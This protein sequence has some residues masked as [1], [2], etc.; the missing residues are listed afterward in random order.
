MSRQHNVPTRREFL[1]QV[2]VVVGVPVAALGAGIGLLRWYNERR[3]V[4]RDGPDR[5]EERYPA[6]ERAE[7]SS[8]LTDRDLEI[9]RRYEDRR[10]EF[11][12]RLYKEEGG[13]PHCKG[14]IYD[15]KLNKLREY[16]KEM[17]KAAEDPVSL[18]TEEDVKGLDAVTPALLS[19]IGNG[20]ETSIFVPDR[21]FD[22]HR[23]QTIDD[24]KSILVDHEGKHV[25]DIFSG[26][27]VGGVK[28]EIIL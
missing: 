15:P 24:G 26:Y 7:F 5:R 25:D 19:S 22:G 3:Q 14:L 23:I 10:Q 11:L 20:V 28:I 4:V 16:E 8:P 17:A 18:S 27:I 6:V 13:I 12:D 1:G 21:F 2:A 9:A